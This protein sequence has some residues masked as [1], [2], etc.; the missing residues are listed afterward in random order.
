M[1]LKNISAPSIK[2]QLAALAQLYADQLPQKIQEI[3]DLLQ[4]LSDLGWEQTQGETLHRMLHSMAGTAGTMGLQQVSQIAREIEQI[5]KEIVHGQTDLQ[6]QMAQLKLGLERLYAAS[7]ETA[8]EPT[9]PLT[10]VTALAA[11]MNILVVDDDPVGQALLSAFLKADGHTVVTA[12]DGVDGVARFSEMQPD[13]V[14]MDVIMPKMNGYEAARK[15]KAACGNDFVPLIFL[16][17]LQ[18]EN[19]LAEC[20]A[21]GGDDFVVKP[22]NRVLLKS[23]LIAMQRIR[24]L[25]H[26]LAQY[27]QRTA[28]EIALSK[29]VFD[30]ATNRNPKLAAVRH[31]H[32]AVGHFSG[33]VILYSHTPSGRLILMLGD[34]TGHG[35]GAALAAVPVSDLFY[36]LVESDVALP[37]LVRAIN[38]K[39]K[40]IMPTGRFCAALLIAV[41][42]DGRQAEVWNGGIPGAYL[43]DEHGCI[44]RRIASSK[45]PLGIVGDQGFDAESEMVAINSGMHFLFFSDGV[46]EARNPQGEM[47]TLAGVEKLFSGNDALVAL[48]AGFARHL[49]GH[50]ADDDISIVAF[51]LGQ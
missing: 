35:L 26:E 18:D 29:H 33:D 2:D 17:A 7:D 30:A 43:L 11:P 34:F 51:D 47:L 9:K 41:S 32:S 22:Y 28:E 36:S 23:K 38:R 15:I 3:R 21:A 13:L 48:Q 44:Q 4:G 5:L 14:F 45:L 42:A 16:T 12:M 25:H 6:A 49:A 19:D 31:W 10:T 50:E 27:Q 20:I 46:N 24:T 39:L 37:D 8:G 1:E 40:S